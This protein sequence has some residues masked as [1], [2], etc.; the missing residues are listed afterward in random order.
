[1]GKETIVAAMKQDMV[2][3]GAAWDALCLSQAVI[4]FELDG[5]ILWANSV[6]LDLMGYRLEDVVGH[7]HRMFCTGDYVASAAYADFW[8]TLA[9]G[10]FASGL[11]K[12][13]GRD[14]RE[15]WLQASYNPV[16]D[17]TTGQPVRVLKIASD[18]TEDQRRTAEADSMIAAISRSQS[19]AEFALDGTVL[20][21]NANFLADM[22]YR[23]EEL[24]GKHHSILCDPADV[25]SPDYQAFWKRLENGL[26]DRGTYRRRTRTGQDVWLHASYNPV[27]DADGRPVRIVKIASNVSR[28]VELENEVKRRLLEGGA[29]QQQLKARGDALE[30]VIGNLALIVTTIA[31]IAS[32]TKLLALNAAI[33]AARA[34]DA[35]RGFAVVA[36]EVKKLASETQAATE[37]AR[38]IVEEESLA[39]KIR[40]RAGEDGQEDPRGTYTPL[41]PVPAP[42]SAPLSTPPHTEGAA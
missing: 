24:V 23:R 13:I 20:D 12:R 34:G 5:R 42:G 25:A 18:V 30:K 29:F 14:G 4:E 17:E 40:S 32:Q 10:R 33:E 11:F 3:K 16:R 1:M 27:L 15:V 39:W 22:D 2:S 41:N 28:Q 9:Q 8:D 31:G 7:H 36:S 38:S 6:F 35:G 37:Q 26:F 21:A 19:V